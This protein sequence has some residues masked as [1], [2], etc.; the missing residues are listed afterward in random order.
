LSETGDKPKRSFPKVPN[1]IPFVNNAKDYGRL[2]ISGKRIRENL[3]TSP[4]AIGQIS[5]PDRHPRKKCCD[6]G[7][8]RNT[9]Y[10]HA[11]GSFTKKL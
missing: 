3:Q 8:E 1:L 7:T 6:F 9:C 2:K 11:A 5:T 10:V 4:Q